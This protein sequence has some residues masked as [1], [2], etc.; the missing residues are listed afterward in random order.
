MLQQR[1]RLGSVA[2][3]QKDWAVDIEGDGKGLQRSRI[4]PECSETHLSIIRMR[5]CSTTLLA[6][7]AQW[8][9]WL[10]GLTNHIHCCSRYR[11]AARTGSEPQY[12]DAR[13]PAVKQ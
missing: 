4:I 5:D 11:L 8:R 6:F 2:R 13:S 12:N 10:R 7:P 3:V 9:H 1:Y